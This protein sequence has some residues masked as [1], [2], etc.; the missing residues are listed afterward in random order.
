MPVRHFY[1]LSHYI[2]QWSILF[3]FCLLAPEGMNAIVFEERRRRGQ[4]ATTYSLR[5]AEPFSSFTDDKM[6]L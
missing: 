5:Y 4:E 2:L 3:I 6:L 1:L